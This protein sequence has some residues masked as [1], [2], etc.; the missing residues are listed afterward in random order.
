MKAWIP[1]TLVFALAAAANAQATCIYP[2]SPDAPP[3]GKTA[4]K[5]QMVAAAQDFK[6]YNGEMNAYLECIKLEMNAAMPADPKKLTPDEKKK[7]D[8][9]Q[10][11]LMQKNNAAVDELQSVVGRFNEQLRI[12]KATNK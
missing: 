4:T 6:R 11:I 2:K 8:D 9:Q 1:L 10:K 3:D 7:S 12:Y 5:D